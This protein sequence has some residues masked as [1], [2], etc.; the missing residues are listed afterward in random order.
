MS[1]LSSFQFPLNVAVI[2]ASGGIGSAL[3]GH[4]ARSS[5]TARIYALSRSKTSFDHSSVD[6]G[7]ID[8]ENEDSIRSAAELVTADEPLDIVIITTGLL[9]DGEDVQPEKNLTA[10]NAEILRRAFNINTVGPALIAKHFLPHL[11]RDRKTVFA[12]LSARVGSISDNRL[13]GWYAYRASKAALNM[14]IRS[15][16]IEIARRNKQAIVVGLH[17]GTV[18]TGLSK[19]FQANVPSGKLFTPAFAAGQLIDVIDQCQ[20]SDT[21]K[22]LAWD[23]QEIPY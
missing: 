3:V 17:P 22:L 10:L 14:I 2:G 18:D 13:G 23:G 6:T 7:F 16:S 12:A 1:D 21:G 4:F 15:A 19:P 9:H 20:S 5:K 8:L 11:R